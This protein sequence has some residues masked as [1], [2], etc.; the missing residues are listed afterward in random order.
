MNLQGLI[1]HQDTGEHREKA[2]SYT[3][4]EELKSNMTH[5]GKTS[6]ERKSQKREILID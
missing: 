3:N 1:N 2:G 4:G 6:K 5:E